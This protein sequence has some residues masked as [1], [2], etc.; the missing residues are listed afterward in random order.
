MVA[1]DEVH[2]SLKIALG[3]IPIRKFEV[4]VSIGDSRLY[5][6]HIH[7]LCILATLFILK[8]HWNVGIHPHAST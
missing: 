2:V 7:V 4:T 3:Y 6:D 1:V 8:T 5:E